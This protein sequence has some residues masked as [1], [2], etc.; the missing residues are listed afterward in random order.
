MEKEGCENC[1]LLLK[2][3]EELEKRLLAYENAHTPP[4]E[5]RGQRHYPQSGLSSRPRGAPQGHQGSTRVFHQPTET[6]ILSLEQCPDCQSHF[7]QPKHVERRVIEEIPEPQSIRVI[8]FF[9]PRY[10]CSK[11]NK[12]IIAHHPELPKSGRLG[13][14]LQAQ[15]VLSKYED[16]LPYRK[17]ESML[18]RQ[19]GI[20]LTAS[21][22]LEVKS[23]VAQQLEP[24]YEKIQQEV[25]NSNRC[26][27]DETGSKLDGKKCCGFL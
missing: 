10:W 21:T 18:R 20:T 2:R 17:I 25:R 14:N 5:Q 1:I 6:N 16:R 19:H 22:I 4:S 3:I 9:V 13:N 15:I 26:N 11:C 8:E 7:G 24:T 12:E 27:A 23:R